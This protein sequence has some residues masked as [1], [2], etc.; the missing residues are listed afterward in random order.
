MLS[1]LGL[2]MQ[3]AA[4]MWMTVGLVAGFVVGVLPGFQ[5]ANATAIALPFSLFIPVEQALLLMVG[6]Y[7]GAAFAGGVPAILVNVPGTA[8]A[9]AT[10]LD[11]YPM[12]LQGRAAEA[13]GIARMAST[14]GGVISM[15]IILGI[16]GPLADLALNFGAREMV[17]VVA[18]GILIIGGLVNESPLKGIFS[19]V[20]GMLIAAMS[21]SPVSGAS[22]FTMGFIELYEG[23]PIVPALIGLFAFTQMILL[24]GQSAMEVPRLQDLDAADTSHGSADASRR[25]SGLRQLFAETTA[26]M[27]TTFKYPKT[28]LRSSIVGML[29]GIAP[30]GGTSVGSFLGWTMA[31]RASKDP[32]SFGKGNPEGVVACETADNAVTGGTLVPTLAL[33]IPGSASAAIML[34]ALVMHG[35]TP[36]P[37]VMTDYAPEAYSVL[38]GVLLASALILPVGI[39]LAAPMTLITRASPKVLVPCLLVVSVAGVFATRNQMFD[40]ALALAF[41][42]LG[43]VM[44]KFGIPVIPMVLGL[45]LGPLGERYLMRSLELGRYKASYFFESPLAIGLWVILLGVAVLSII[46][47]FKRKETTSEPGDDETALAREAEDSLAD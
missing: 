23:I 38:L 19:A 42:I 5:S 22:R 34:A 44:L 6:I 33:G 12:R 43:Y 31:R 16:M 24:S 37:R 27:Q 1:G 9:A 2:L 29:I 39:L 15:V 40:V 4:L 28:I 13:I 30:G 18:F 45:I 41:G 32:S 17:L 21:A 8:S 25:S 46:K 20:L 11:G 7:C 14:L 10:A 36:G 47:I 3:P 35:I 26:G